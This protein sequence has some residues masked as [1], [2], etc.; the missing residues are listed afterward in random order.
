VPADPADNLTARQQL[1]RACAELRRRLRGGEDCGAEE[2]LA[3]YPGLADSDQDAISLILTEFVVRRQLGRAP[4]HDEMLARFPRWRE[5]LAPLLA[6]DG[7]LSGST[8]AAATDQVTGTDWPALT[9]A[10]T[11]GAAFA[12][13]ELLGRLG[14]GGMGVVYRAWD[15]MLKRTVALKMIR[16]GALATDTEVERF[17]REARAAA[18]LQHPNIVALYEFGQHQGYSYFTMAL[19][20]GGSLKGHAGRFHDPREAAALLEKIARAVQHAHEKGIVHRDLKPANVLLDDAGEPLVADFG[21]AK[22]AEGDAELTRTGQVL[23]T[24][25]YMAPEQA[26]RRAQSATEQTDVWALGVMLYELVTGRR[27]FV[28]DDPADL[29]RLILTADPPRPCDLRPGLDRGLETIILRALAKSPG[30]RYPSAGRLADDL[31]AWL[32]GEPIWAR[33]EGR[34]RRARRALRRHPALALAAACFAL[35]LAAALAGLLWF[36]SRPP[37]G[38]VELIVHDGDGVRGRWAVGSGTAT[39]LDDGSLQL[40]VDRKALGMWELLKAPPWPRYRYEVEVQ[41]VGQAGYVGMYLNHQRLT[42]AG[43]E[44]WFLAFSFAERDE[45]ELPVSKVLQAQGEVT[46]RRLVRPAAGGFSDNSRALLGSLPYFPANP[47]EWRQLVLDVTPDVVSGFWGDSAQPFDSVPQSPTVEQCRRELADVVPGQ[48]AAP[49][50]A[51]TRGG[52]GVFCQG[53]AA[54]FRN[55]VVRPLP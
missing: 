51:T 35:A 45:Y 23:G 43:E 8:E 50:P 22:F 55:A 39:P 36:S 52:L 9:P 26:A 40:E 47:G 32:A 44:D 38:P 12:H 3:A 29:E 19:A 10:P 11:P 15:P 46:Y 21:L 49:P 54:R 31:R 14:R 41:Q 37:R 25:A 4:G 17:G 33:P 7:L 28:A 53:G 20:G 1:D 2:Y 48:Q 16:D 34:L 5:L 42:P 13:Y 6:A 18:R 24:V 27:P 30:E